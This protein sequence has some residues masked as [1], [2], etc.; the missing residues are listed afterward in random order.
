MLGIFDLVKGVDEVVVFVEEYGLLIVIKV[1]YGGGGKGMKVVCIIGEILELY[2]LV[3]CE[4][5]VV[6]GCGE[7]YVECYFD[8]LCYVE[9]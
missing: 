3:V 2:E 6:F 8:K 5:M 9:V 1:V 4:V 7:C